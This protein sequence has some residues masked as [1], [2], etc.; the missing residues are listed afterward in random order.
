MDTETADCSVYRLHGSSELSQ[1]D[2]AARVEYVI[3]VEA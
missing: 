2:A 1:R 3:L